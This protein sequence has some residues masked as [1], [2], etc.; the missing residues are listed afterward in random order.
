VLRIDGRDYSVEHLEGQTWKQTPQAI[1]VLRSATVKVVDGERQ[2]IVHTTQADVGRALD[3]AGVMLYL[4]DAVSPDLSSPV[5]DGLV[6]EIARSVPVTVVADGRQ[7]HTRALGPTVGDAL[8]A[9]GLALIGQDY[10]Q[11][12]G[13]ARLEPDTIIRLVR[14]TEKVIVEQEAIP[15]STVY[16]PDPSLPETQERIVQEGTAGLRERQVRERYEDG[17]IVRR[18]VQHERVMQP[19]VPRLIVYGTRPQ[20]YFPATASPTA[21]AVQL[22]FDNGTGP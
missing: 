6:I 14:V 12:P 3:S 1:Q 8:A 5:Y 20:S 13:T 18:T 15:F 21:F 4:A 19:P 9:I 7:L 22:P 17:Q 11:P 16:R 2:L 10:T